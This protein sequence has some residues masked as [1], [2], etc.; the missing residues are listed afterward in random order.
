MGDR[1]LGNN[2]L[3]LCLLV[4]FGCSTNLEL[5][6]N[7]HHF[8]RIP[9]NIIWIQLAGLSDTHIPFLKYLQ[10]SNKNR[11]FESA[12]CMGKTFDSSY[13]RIR[14]RAVRHF[15]AQIFA[16]NL[17]SKNMCQAFSESIPIWRVFQ[18]EKRKVSILEIGAKKSESL[19]NL[20]DCKEKV[21]S[22]ETLVFKQAPDRA[23][24]DQLYD[25]EKNRQL[26][27]GI[28]FEKNCQTNGRCRGD[29]LDSMKYFVK[30]S[31]R[32]G[33][34]NFLQ[35]RDFTYAR[36]INKGQLKQAR[37]HLMR[38]T[39]FIQWIEGETY[40]ENKTLTL[41]TGATPIY[42]EFPRQGRQWVK[43]EK[44]SKGLKLRS[45]EL[46]SPV[47]SWGASS[48]LFCGIMDN[49]D[50][51]KRMYG[52]FFQKKFEIKNLLESIKRR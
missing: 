44:S 36:L 18:E 52:R 47:F 29:N 1:N 31:H 16:T 19:L 13:E 26:N 20:R 17:V 25:L 3:L 48:E 14:P 34:V 39:E 2:A 37:S 51:S 28:F 43:F 11:F 4:F 46:M 23:F 5:G 32:A 22:D 30:N 38:L 10:G 50:I 40:L 41:L 49:V 15:N 8:G 45:S 33:K 42:L 24:S 6:G 7:R 21:L 27:K 9:Q 12:T 35:I